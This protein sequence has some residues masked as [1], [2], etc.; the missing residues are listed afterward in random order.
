M[1]WTW[2]TKTNLFNNI[3]IMKRNFILA[4]VALF[5]AASCQKNIPTESVY[6]APTGLLTVEVGNDASVTKV[7]DAV[8]KEHQI[9][10][11][12]VFVF[13]ESGALE[14]DLY[15]TYQ[16]GSNEPYSLSLTTRIGKKNV[17]AVV[18]AP[19]LKHTS[20]Q[21]LETDLSDLADNRVANGSTQSNLVMT[22]MASTTVVEYS[23]L[24]ATP[25]PCTIM[26]KKLASAI[27]LS[28]VTTEFANTT[29]EGCSFKIKE[30]YVKNV[31]GKAPYSFSAVLSDEQRRMPANWY[32]KLVLDAKPIPVTYD[33]CDLPAVSSATINVNRTLYVYPNSTVKDPDTLP[34]GSVEYAPRP[35]RL[36]V[37]AVISAS[38]DHYAGTLTD[39]DFYYT[40]DLPVLEAN[41]KYKVSI[42]ISMLGKT[43][44]N[45]DSKTTSGYSQ[46]TITVSDWDEVIDL[47]YHM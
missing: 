10:S 32:N 38:P 28:T 44:D 1:A 3:I 17:F 33:L 27:Q 26:V 41:K 8:M 6:E 36:V 9:N 16:P 39:K 2:T 4:A 23:K 42:V 43:S 19:R 21:S 29:L 15:K 14:T 31:V 37:H 40:F 5:T 45:D 47:T 22:G 30:I 35:T 18:N 7:S 20:I 11:V 24:S 13:T 46:P 12:Q 25:T 34:G